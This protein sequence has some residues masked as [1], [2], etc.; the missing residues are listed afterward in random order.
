MVETGPCWGGHRAD[1]GGSRRLVCAV[2]PLPIHTLPSAELQGRAQGLSTQDPTIPAL[3]PP[4][5]KRLIKAGLHH[6]QE[7]NERPQSPR[8]RP[9]SSVFLS[10][11]LGELFGTD[12]GGE[13]TKTALRGTPWVCKAA[14]IARAGSRRRAPAKQPWCNGALPRPHRAAHTARQS[15]AAAQTRGRRALRPGLGPREAW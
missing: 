2:T 10:K 1:R 6:T 13:R 12:A 5:S 15:S 3:H 4:F 14:E 9:F 8:R 7:G 11:T